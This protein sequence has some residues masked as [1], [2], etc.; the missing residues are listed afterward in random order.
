MC[1]AELQTICTE[2]WKRI[3]GLEG[4]KYDLE[5]IEILKKLEVTFRPAQSFINTFDYFNLFILL[6]MQNKKQ[7]SL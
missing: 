4:D 3:N 7:K 2:Y 5:R 6:I 1:V